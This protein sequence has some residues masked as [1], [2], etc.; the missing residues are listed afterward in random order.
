[1]KSGFGSCL[2]PDYLAPEFPGVRIVP[3]D[4]RWSRSHGVY[5]HDENSSPLLKAFLHELASSGV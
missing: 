2:L 1:M 4:Y 5:Y 3:C